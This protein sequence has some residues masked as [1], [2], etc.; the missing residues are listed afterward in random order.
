MLKLTLKPGEFIDIGDN[1][2]VVFSG[3]SSKNIRLLIDAPRSLNIARSNAVHGGAGPQTG[4]YREP[5]ISPQAKRQ[6]AR[7]LKEERRKQA[8]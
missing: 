6:I 5:D 7:I 1:I 3:G 2:R 8:R 4:Y